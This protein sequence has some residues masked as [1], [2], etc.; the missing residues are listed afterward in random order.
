MKSLFTPIMTA[1]MVIAGCTTPSST[2][3]SAPAPSTTVNAFCKSISDDIDEKENKL[4]NPEKAIKKL[5]TCIDYIEKSSN[6]EALAAMDYLL[7]SM[8]YEQL[9]QYSLAI[10]DMEKHI[11]LKGKRKTGRDIVELSALYRNNKQPEKA[12]SILQKMFDERLGLFGKGTT[13]GMPSYYHLGRAL[14]DLKR[15]EEAAEAFTE[16]LTYQPDYPWAL[17]YRAL[18]YDAL[19][20]KSLASADI[21]KARDLIDKMQAQ[22]KSKSLEALGKPPFPEFL[23]KYPRHR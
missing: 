13:F 22:D 7:R 2:N 14:I 18:A 20:Q 10:S 6:N 11:S 5:S 23:S 8:A 3:T 16:G 21:G 19:G 4:K 15:W 17:M 1:S 12:V 9:G